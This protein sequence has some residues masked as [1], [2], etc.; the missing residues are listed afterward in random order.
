[1]NPSLQTLYL[2]KIKPQL[3]KKFEYNN[4]HNIPKLVKITVNRGLGE[5]SQ[6]AKSM[7]N[8]L[9]ELT[10]ITGQKP[11]IT[12]AKKSIAGF[13]IREKV[14][15]GIMVT[16]RRQKMYDFLNKLVNLAL[17]RIRDFRGISN[18]NFDG[19]GNYNLGL[20]E[21]LI[22][23]EVEYNNVDQVRGMNISIVTTAKTDQES[24]ALLQGFGMP[25]KNQFSSNL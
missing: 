23:P 5:T 20:K 10:L 6:N 4:V 7:E 24:L 9:L 16:L 25:F 2:N 22:F 19:R 17:P 8:S 1:M 11:V 18:Q 12:R 3:R 15:I 21:Q 13:K 14:P